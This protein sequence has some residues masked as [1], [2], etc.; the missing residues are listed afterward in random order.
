MRRAVLALMGLACVGASCPKPQKS[1]GGAAAKPVDITLF[2]MTELRGWI[3]PCGCTSDPLGDLARTT[4]YVAKARGERPA[5]L[6]DGGSTLYT[7]VQIP[8]AKRDQERLRSEL[9]VKYLPSLGLVASG[10]GPHDLASGKDAVRLARQAANVRDPALPLEAPKV[11]EIGGARVGVFGVVD[12]ELV[13]P[14]GLQA[15]DPAEA[16]RQAI[17]RLRG[18]GAQVIVAIAHMSRPKARK[19]ARE[20]PGAHLI[21]V[22]RDAPEPTDRR[23]YD[24]LE[25]V[26]GAYL[27]QPFGR[28]Q[29]IVRV[30]LHLEP[31]AGPIVDAVGPARAASRLAE[32]E[33]A[34]AT[35]RPKVEAWERDPSAE[36]AF[37]A[38]QRKALDQMVAE[39]DALARDPL[40]KPARGS[41]LVAANVPIKKAMPCD[42]EVQAAKK[43]YDKQVGELNLAAA[44]EEKLPPVPDG[45]AGY[46]GIEECGFCH[47]EAVEFWK[48]TKHAQ[49]WQTLVD[50]EKQYDRDCIGCHVTGYMEPGGSTL[51]LNETLRDVQCETCH[52]PASLHVDADGKEKPKSLVLAPPEERCA[53]A[54]HTPEHSDTFD[55]TAYLRDVTGPGH[56]EAYRKRLGDGPTGD[57]LRR[58]ALERAGAAIGEGCL[59]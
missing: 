1:E 13:A 50:L 58:A 39:R 57:E 36:A 48:K 55:Y 40:R 4:A 21:L 41:W 47:R 44:R 18:Q 27:V 17:T 53:L 14:L 24:A 10:L 7:E 6:I 16:A 34:I 8:D 42:R 25:E 2:F 59:K 9:I 46:V 20:A 5:A 23:P 49:A 31:G 15:G 43:A 22:G 45:G 26:G 38:E 28:G 33:Q 52:G 3:E 30:D 11:V 29:S 32:L 19:L 35:L 37:V 12:P 54:C 51:A 56:G